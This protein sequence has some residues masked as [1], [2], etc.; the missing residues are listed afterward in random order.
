VGNEQHHPGTPLH[1]DRSKSTDEGDA[2]KTPHGS[3]NIGYRRSSSFREGLLE[4]A[5]IAQRE[6]ENEQPELNII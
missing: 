4:I 1:W 3:W 6:I 5:F 2:V